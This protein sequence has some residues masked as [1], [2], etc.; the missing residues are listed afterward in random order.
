VLVIAPRTRQRIDKGCNDLVFTDRF[1]LEPGIV[2]MGEN[3]GFWKQ[4]A[5][6]PRG[7]FR[8]PAWK[9][10]KNGRSPRACRLFSHRLK[11]LTAYPDKGMPQTG[12]RLTRFGHASTL[13]VCVISLPGHVLPRDREALLGGKIA[14]THH[15]QYHSAGLRSVVLAF[16]IPF[17]NEVDLRQ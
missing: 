6:A 4:L 11:I 13:R 12:A 17:R 16:A 10:A 7:L 8:R 2:N 3:I 1:G 9:R 15:R 14:R 5:K